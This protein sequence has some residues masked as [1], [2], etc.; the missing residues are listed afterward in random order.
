MANITVLYVN[1]ASKEG[2][3]KL[4][5]T[6][7]IQLAIWLAAS[8]VLLQENFKPCRCVYQLHAYFIGLL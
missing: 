2:S 1:I 5:Y 7:H 4:L 3:Y 6:M 8:M